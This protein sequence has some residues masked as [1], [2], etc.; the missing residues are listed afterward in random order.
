MIVRF[1][2][3]KPQNLAANLGHRVKGA[4]LIIVFGER[5]T[6]Q[7]KMDGDLRSQ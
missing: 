3:G 7:T 2:R 5:E 1:E 6:R 4:L